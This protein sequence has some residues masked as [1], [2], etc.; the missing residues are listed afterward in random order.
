MLLL[1]HDLVEAAKQQAAI[2]QEK[3][4]LLLAHREDEKM[5]SEYTNDQKLEHT[6][7]KRF[8]CL[9]ADLRAESRRLSNGMSSM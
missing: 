2:R 9:R 8:S 1:Q 7:S 5:Y 6:S 3:D 4:A